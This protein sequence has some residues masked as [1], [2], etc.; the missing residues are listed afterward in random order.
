MRNFSTL[1]LATVLLVSA[2]L[3]FGCGSSNDFVSTGTGIGL[4]APVA[5]D[6]AYNA[7]GNTTL[8]E[9]AASGVLRGDT[10][11][12]GTVTAFDNPTA[13]GGSVNVAAD[14]AFVY[15]PPVGFVGSDSFTYTLTGPGGQSTATV[16]LTTSQLLWY[17]DNTSGG[18][19]GTFATPFS[20]L[21]AAVNA[22]A[23]NETIFILAGDNTS[24]GLTGPVTLKA[25]QTLIGEAEGLD[26]DDFL[27]RQIV[28][29]GVRPQLMGPITVADGVTLRGLR[30]LPTAAGSALVGSSISNL[31][32]DNISAPGAQPFD[33][34]SIE[35]D[36]DCTV[37]NSTLGSGFFRPTGSALVN[38]TS[39]DNVWASG[40]GISGS[41]TSTTTC[42]FT[43]D[44][45][46]FQVDATDNAT[47]SATLSNCTGRPVFSS[48]VTA[49]AT[50][51]IT[52]SNLGDL[53]VAPNTANSSVNVSVT[54][55][56]VGTVSNGFNNG[57]IRLEMTRVSQPFPGG[58]WSLNGSGGGIAWILTDC[59]VDNLEIFGALTD[60][61]R[62]TG[63]TYEVVNLDTMTVDDLPNFIPNNTV[64]GLLTTTNSVDGVCP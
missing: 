45:L 20:T 24:T 13:Q 29:P 8:T 49:V 54:D 38:F 31:T 47:V 58:F 27:P 63:G 28:Q 57:S 48:S 10:V 25:G 3:T 60:C 53:N 43:R 4:A 56:T 64:T 5:A 61:I 1:R 18:G 12:G 23:V 62:S 46:V 35:L 30:I 15:N 51:Q 14:G 6:D 34:I 52:N 21:A 2:L 22:A 7:L 42:S 17:V 16:T 55:S 37:T 44:D 33:M 19:D 32:L 40:A 59:T 39:S 41:D 11:N 50:G 9:D 36:G 26:L